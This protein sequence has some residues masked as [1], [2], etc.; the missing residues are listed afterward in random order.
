MKKHRE[1]TLN[2]STHLILKDIKLLNKAKKYALFYFFLRFDLFR[3]LNY[4]KK[5]KTP[6]I[7]D[8]GRF[9]IKNF[10]PSL[11]AEYHLQDTFRLFEQIRGSRKISLDT[12][13]HQW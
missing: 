2:D 13:E 7:N 10:L 12:I 6:K 1:I 9:I 8:F 4:Q 3:N 11:Y 5:I